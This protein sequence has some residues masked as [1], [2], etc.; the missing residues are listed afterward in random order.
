MYEIQAAEPRKFEFS[1]NDKKYSVPLLTDMPYSVIKSLMEIRDSGDSLKVSD[2]YV[3]FFEEHAK[4]CTDKLS[5][6]QLVA[7]FEAYDK[8]CNTGE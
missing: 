5:F 2:W 8:A 4:G 3:S 7:L 6:S 1:V